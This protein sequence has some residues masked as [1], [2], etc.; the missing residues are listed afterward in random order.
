MLF[1]S[2]RQ[3]LWEAFLTDSEAGVFTHDRRGDL[4]SITPGFS[5]CSVRRRC[6]RNLD[7]APATSHNA[8]QKTVVTAIYLKFIISYCFFEK[9]SEK[10]DASGVTVTARNAPSRLRGVVLPSAKT[11]FLTPKE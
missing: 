10:A 4:V 2:R 6:G 5:I 3:A 1:R 8:T 7:A 11:A 9:V